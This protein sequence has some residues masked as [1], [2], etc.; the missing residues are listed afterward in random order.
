MPVPVA[1]IAVDK[2]AYHFDKAYDYRIPQGLS[3][4]APGCRVLVS[5]GGSRR[6]G[7][8]LALGEGEEDD[9]L[10]EVL[11][12]L[13]DRPVLGEEQLRLLEVLKQTTFC[14]YF[15]GLRVLLPPGLGLQARHG[16]RLTGKGRQL[17]EETEEEDRPLTATQEGIL[18]ALRRRRGDFP[19]EDLYEAFGILSSSRELT[20]LQEQGLVEKVERLRRRVLDD[21]QVMVRMG[22]TP[23][24]RPTAKQQ[25]VLDLLEQAGQA[26]L[27]ELCYF[28]G[29]TRAVV[30]RL[31]AT[32]GVELYQVE[33]YRD[34]YGDRDPLPR[35]A[36]P[37]LSPPQ[38]EALDRL[39]AL[40]KEAAPQALLYG[41]TGSGKTQ[42][43]LGLID[44]LLEEKKGVIV[45]VPEISL[46]PQTIRLFHQRFG[47]RVA[48]LHSSLS[49]SQRL[50]EWKRV[51]AGLADIVVGT[52]SAVF[53]PVQNLGAIIV[54][55]E[56][57]HTY[58]SQQSPRY[59]AREIARLRCRWAG[60]LLLLCSAT[61]SLESFYAAQKGRMALVTLPQR[62]GQASLP[63]VTILDMRQG[64]GEE[65]FSQPL[66]EEICQNLERGEQT[67][68]L[69]NRRG[70]STQVKCMSCGAPALC[71]HCSIGMTYHSANGRLV[72]HY[73]GYTTT[74]L[75]A[76][77]TCGSPMMRYSGLGTQRAEER[78]RE[79][80]PQARILRMDAD[81]NLSR[82][83]YEHH[84]AG[85][86]DGRYDI[87]IG[88]QMVAKG[89]DFPRVTLVGVLAADQSLYGDDFRSYERTFSLITQVV[90]RC[91]RGELPGRA[92]IQTYTPDNPVIELAATQRYEDFYRD[93]I[94]SRRLH[95]Y[96]PFCRIFCVGFTGLEQER[97][98]Q[99]AL[100]FA[101][102]FAALAGSEYAGLPLRLL[103]P[104]EAA[105]LRVAGRYRYK[106]LVKC[107]AGAQTNQLFS[108]V[109]TA[110]LRDKEN[111]GVAAFIDPWYDAGF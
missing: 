6:Q 74:R 14:T 43:F 34:P 13:D 79:L 12:Q 88:T 15:D 70:H 46:T 32:G 107:R 57:E 73:C 28:A 5:F 100:R 108:R 19:A 58:R 102:D 83:S 61:P 55:E 41:V 110:F 106:L 20:G 62:Y 111:K 65:G 103:G 37:P 18:E 30:D 82:D 36:P 31:A 101:R 75:E 26:S 78:L 21:R 104:S 87:M 8:V 77:P 17:L 54:D 49:M 60:G 48:V 45:M 16:Y 4:L 91:G 81:T 64:A 23:P 7:I 29:V 95:L 94:A 85:F 90:G 80:F 38:Q 42:V 93:E 66:L 22:E 53:A 51:R 92:F 84:L 3:S 63:D 109:L 24:A 96:P 33:R 44:R 59:D 52:R 47:K 9:R 98:R 10:K 1:K 68:L 25:A 105:L 2:A 39:L 97:V 86:R 56:Q 27:K 69:L 11:E 99:G 50:D 67:I 89:L 76:C 71:P 40:R 35:L 72:C